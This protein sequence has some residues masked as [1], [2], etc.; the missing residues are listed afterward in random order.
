MREPMAEISNSSP[1]FGKRPNHEMVTL[2]REARGMT[3]K[4]LSEELGLSPGY[5]SKLESGF[6]SPSEEIITKLSAVLNYPP[7][8]FYQAHRVYGPSTSEFYHRKRKAAS[9]KE[10]A[11]IHAEINI[12][13]NHVSCFLRAAELEKH[14]FPRLD[15]EEFDSSVAEVARAVRSQWG[16]PSGPVKSVIDVIEDAGG[17]VIRFPFK[18]RLVDAVS[19]WVPGMPPMFFVNEE[20]PPDR[21]RL[22]LAHE[23]GHMI[24]H[25]T[26]RPEIEEEANAFVAEFLMPESDIRPQLHDLSLHKLASL[27]M[28]WKTSMAALLYRASTLGVIQRGK[29]EYL[30]KQIAR[31]GYRMREPVEL[32]PPTEEPTTMQD[33]ID[34]HCVEYGYSIEQLSKMCN[35]HEPELV[36]TYRISQTN[37]DKRGPLRLVK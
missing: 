12:R 31:L 14:D 19:R 2:A 36:A 24:M 34:L 5:L 9:A 25:Q 30:W 11:R 4:E 10:V 8:F 13:M 20:L 29:S 27:K 17:I 37:G 21:E 32:D 18:T 33:L 7:T 28:H 6:M 1:G 15:P 26:V 23:L 16:L 3:Q 35:W 22:T